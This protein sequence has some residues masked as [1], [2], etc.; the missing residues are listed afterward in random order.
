MFFKFKII[1]TIPSAFDGGSTLNSSS[2]SQQLYPDDARI[3]FFCFLCMLVNY[4]AA[5]IYHLMLILNRFLC[6]NPGVT[7]F[8]LAVDLL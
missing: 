4:C 6:S 3:S 8:M 2:G 5:G 1:R 7:E